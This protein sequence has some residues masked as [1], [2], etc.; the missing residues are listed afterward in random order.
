M[1]IP[2]ILTIALCSPVFANADTVFCGRALGHDY[3]QEVELPC[4]P[5]SICMSNWYRWKLQVDAVL[6]GPPLARQVVA[7][8]I[9][10]GKYSSTAEEQLRL[11]TVKPI[12]D[13]EK[14]KLLGAD[15]SLVE[16][17]PGKNAA[18]ASCI[19]GS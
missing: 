8:T 13:E 7:V 9:Q 19:R 3:I 11:F 18:A 14:R 17:L 10:H 12:E 16:K 4:P 1:R 15:F 5:N 6:S 2:F